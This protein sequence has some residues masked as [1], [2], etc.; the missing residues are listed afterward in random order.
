MKLV[1]FGTERTIVVE[2]HSGK[3]TLAV[4]DDGEA[5]VLLGGD[6]AVTPEPGKKYRMAFTA[7]GKMGGY[8]RITAEAPLLPTA[9]RTADA[10]EC[11]KRRY[12]DK[13]SA[14]SEINERTTGGHWRSRRNR[15]AFLRAYHCDRCGG[16]HL[17]H[18]EER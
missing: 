2:R 17:T 9:P 3:V 15:P 8:W 13:K 7:G 11:R 1:P 6:H 16:W 4:G 12:P 10:S 5:Y 14:V 18:K